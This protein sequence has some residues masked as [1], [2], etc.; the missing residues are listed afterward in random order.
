MICE[1]V[2]L[3]KKINTSTSYCEY[4]KNN[5]LELDLD[6]DLLSKKYPLFRTS[7][8]YLIRK[9]NKFE[10][11]LGETLHEIQMSPSDFYKKKSEGKGIPCYR[12]AVGKSRIYFPIIC[13]ALY[14]SSDFVLVER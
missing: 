12:Q 11:S 8:E 14:L 13:I 2:V 10:L 6:I 9:Y 5:L 1:G 7:Y 4:Y 3:N